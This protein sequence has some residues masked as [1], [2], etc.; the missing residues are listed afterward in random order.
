VSKEEWIVHKNAHEPI[1]SKALFYEVRSV[2]DKKKEK[3]SFAARED[4][5]KRKISIKGFSNVP[6]VVRICL[7]NQPLFILK[8]VM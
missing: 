5:P 3:K 6:Y 8:M 2:V 4:L 1:I 7:G